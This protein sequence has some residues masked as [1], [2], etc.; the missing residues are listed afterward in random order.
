MILFLFIP[1]CWFIA[2]SLYIDS[3]AIVAQQL[4]EHAWKKVLT[5][6]TISKPWPWADTW[7]VARLTVPRLKIDLIIL[8]GDNGRT[9][10]FGPGHNV[11]SVLPGSQGNSLISAHRDT[12]F[13]FLQYLQIGDVIH[14]ETAHAKKSLFKVTSTNVVDMDKARFVNVPSQ[15]AIHLVTCFPFD[16]IL[17]GG[18][19][20][21]IVTAVAQNSKV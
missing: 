21:Y 3:K 18:S 12:H 13:N 4:L 16:S 10:A 1:G 9:L 15:A 11:S 19:Q 2:Q 5:D 8:A 14:I 6:D 20:R 7:P 17:T